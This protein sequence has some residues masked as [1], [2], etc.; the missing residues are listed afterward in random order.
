[1]TSP[2]ATRRSVLIAGAVAVGLGGLGLELWWQASGRRAGAAAALGG[3]VR[4]D[5]DGV[6][7]RT[8]TTEMGQGTQTALAQILAEELDLDWGT[9]R[10]EMAPLEPGYFNPVT[11]AFMT[12]GST[13]VPGM[14]GPLRRAGATAR[15][16]LRTAAAEAWGVAPESCTTEGGAVVHAPSGRRSP[17]GELAAKAALLPVPTAVELRPPAAWR[18][19][20]KSLPRLDTRSKV[21]GS[22]VFGIDARASGGPPTLSAAIRHCPVFGGTLVAVDASAAERRSGVRAV[23]KLESAVAVVAT[24]YWTAEQALVALKPEWRAVSPPPPSAELMAELRRLTAVD[25]RVTLRPGQDLSSAATASA[26]ALA[27]AAQVFERSYEAPLLAHA[28]LEPMNATAWVTAERARLWV[29]TQVQSQLQRKVAQA[30]SLP[31]ASVEVNTTFLG[32]GFGRR[33]QTDYGVEAALIARAVGAPVKLIWSRAEDLQHDYYRPAA[34]LR[35]RAALGERR[36][37]L[38]LRIN[39][40]CLDA[41]D[42][43]GGLLPPLYDF[44]NYHVSY[45]GSSR[46]VPLGAWRA[47]DHTQNI[48]ALESFLD[49]LALEMGVDALALR[50][51]LLK[52]RPRALA[53]LEGVVALAAAAEPR[54]SRGFAITERSGSYAAEIAEVSLNGGELK[55]H[56]V[57][58]C[59]DCGTVVNPSTVEAQMQGGILFGLS[60]AAYSEITLADGRV[61]ERNFD[62]YPLLTMRAAP[63][64]SV[65]ILERPG[66][67][68]T[69][70]GEPPVP[71]IAAA[72]CNAI[73]KAGPRPRALPLARHG[74]T[75]V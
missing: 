51:S 42:P 41:D 63:E 30:L 35:F 40:G 24:D 69:G 22:A 37:L 13:A 29:P 21:D 33:L 54:G 68:P 52:R 50:R 17:Y 1:M 61:V 48:F 19:I 25:G 75:V 46:G 43:V 49:E 20:G 56:R 44:P 18:L 31:L 15:T 53:A 62:G 38:G 72:L 7:L 59:I 2:S 66:S 55:V 6:T 10:I 28:T 57:F 73:A 27:A 23:V 11:G 4:I 3:W 58:A 65:R 12:G 26:A 70:V 8:N 16:L 32:G 64:V 14:F 74:L 34:V 47:V 36:Q 39:I 60:A 45:A 71:P 67:D 9:V 5:A